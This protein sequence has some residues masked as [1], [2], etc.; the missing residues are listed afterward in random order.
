VARPV[1]REEELKLRRLSRFSKRN[2]RRF[3]RTDPDDRALGEKALRDL[4][5]VAPP[6]TVEAH[7]LGLEFAER[8]GLSI[9]ESMIAAAATL[10][11]FARLWS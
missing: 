8:Y 11:C 5:A 2:C 9:T 4:L 10:N 1:E 7:E 3:R 6:V